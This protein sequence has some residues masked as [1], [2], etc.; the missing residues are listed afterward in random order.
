MNKIFYIKDYKINDNEYNKIKVLNIE[1]EINNNEIY[2]ILNT[3]NKKYFNYFP[4]NIEL[5]HSTKKEFNKIFSFL[6]YQGFV[7]KI[8]LLVNFC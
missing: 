7:N 4:I 2:F 1:K 8:N 6:L 3:N 5:Y